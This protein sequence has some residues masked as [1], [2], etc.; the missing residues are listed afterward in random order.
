M[1]KVADSIRHGLDEAVAYAPGEAITGC[2]C[3][4]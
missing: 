2:M 1:S 4:P 3:R